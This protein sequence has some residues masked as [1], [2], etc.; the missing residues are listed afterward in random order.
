MR[1]FDK[2]LAELR[3]VQVA[4]LELQAF[5]SMERPSPPPVPIAVPKQAAPPAAG[6]HPKP[7]PASLGVGSEPP[8]WRL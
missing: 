5:Q 3:R 6:P 8:S 4:R 2:A 1:D 7:S